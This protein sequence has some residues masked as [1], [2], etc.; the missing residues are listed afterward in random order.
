MIGFISLGIGAVAGAA[1]SMNQERINQQE[2]KYQQLVLMAMQTDNSSPIQQVDGT[3]PGNLVPSSQLPIDATPT[4]GYQPQTGSDPKK[5]IFKSNTEIPVR[6]V[7]SIIIDKTSE[8][9]KQTGDPIWKVALVDSNGKEIETLKALSGRASKQTAN[10]NQGGNK[11][12]LPGG[13]YA[14]DTYG[15]ERG[16]FSDPELGYGY[17]VPISPLFNTGRSALGFHQ[18]PSW[19]KINGESGTSG[20]IG[21]E[22]AEATVK[23]VNWIRQYRVSKVIVTS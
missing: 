3:G 1:V 17:W 9:V 10:R 8:T 21:L 7:F 11:S 13:V 6:P 22:S 5:I 20:C 23:L 2:A 18:D 4:P 12:P 19:G 16:P 15:I 14:I